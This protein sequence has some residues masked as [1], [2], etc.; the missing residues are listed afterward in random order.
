[1]AFKVFAFA[2]LTCLP[3]LAQAAF[4]PEEAAL[5]K[6]ITDVGAKTITLSK[7]IVLTADLP[8]LANGKVLTVR[9]AVGAQFT[10]SGAKKYKLFVAAQDAVVDLTLVRLII[11]GAVEAV[12]IGGEGTKL[13]ID[14]VNF[15]RNDRAL[16]LYV[17]NAKIVNSQ[18]NNHRKGAIYTTSEE[19]LGDDVK[20]S[21]CNFISNK[22]EKGTGGGAI[23][24]GTYASI[25]ADKCFFS[26]N[27][28]DYVGGAVRLRAGYAVISRSTFD[29]NTAKESAGGLSIYRSGV[30]VQDSTFSNNVAQTLEGG[31]VRIAA[32][33]IGAFAQFKNV[34]FKNNK[35]LLKPGGAFVLNGTSEIQFCAFEFTGNTGNGRPSNGAVLPDFDN[36]INTITTLPGVTVPLVTV[37]PGAILETQT[38]ACRP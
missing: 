14:T 10:I 2:L 22:A 27:T 1:M 21:K 31:A 33:D 16:T 25:T 7:N 35:A 23:F 15:D 26:K 19:G 5:R 11:T 38:A 4:S 13:S 3:I 17:V 18:F 34:I 12:N 6:A 36:T 24:V 28:A 20:L 9:S 30:R 37:A 32:D 8:P 29:S